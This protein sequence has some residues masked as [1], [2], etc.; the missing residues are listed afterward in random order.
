MSHIEKQVRVAQNRLWLNR[1]MDQVTICLAVGIL[2]FGV[3]V[4][5]SRLWGLSLPVWR[6]GQIIA[7]LAGLGSAVWLSLRHET[8]AAAASALDEAAGLR[9]RLSTSRF[10]QVAVD[11]AVTGD[12]FAQAV[13]T[14]AD[15]AAR[16]LSVSKIIKLRRPRFLGHLAAAALVAACFFLLPAGWLVRDA[17]AELPPV[18]QAVVDANT[19]IKKRLDDLAKKVEDSTTADLKEDLQALRE[20]ISAPLERP[21]FVRHEALKKIEKLSD[22]VKEKQSDPKF[23]GMNEF[24]RMMRGLTI[25]EKEDVPTKELQKALAQGDFKTAQEE[26]KKLQEQLATLKM[27]EDQEKINQLSEQLEKIAEELQKAAANKQ[28]EQKLQ[29]AGIKPDDLKRMLENLSKEDLQQVQ[30]QLEQQGM[31]QQQIDQIVKQMQQN[32]MAGSAAKQMANNMKQAA[33]CNNP[34]Q[35]G[36]AMSGLSQAADQLS[37]LE[38][39]QAEMAQLDSTMQSLN[40]AQN[41]MGGDCP[42]CKGTGQCKGGPCSSCKGSGM[43]QGQNRNGM[44][45]KPGQGQGGVAPEEQT[46]VDFKVERQQLDTRKGAI[47]GQFLVDGEQV[48]G[49]VTSQLVEVISAAER[50]ATDNVERDRIPR[51]YQSAVRSYFSSVKSALEGMKKKPDGAKEGEGK[52]DEG[53]EAKEATTPSSP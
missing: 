36:Q 8:S 25:P 47:I 23:D 9:E 24:R 48:E 22:A 19:Q 5:V 16:D 11:P 13:V 6:I 45:P 35:M 33:Q 7:A 46:S 15:R 18:S 41:E 53:A 37:D 17:Q 30:K 44:G 40:Q 39:M 10:L 51:H 14:D 29:Q 38:A 3:V 32:Q 21:D 52:G 50:D 49:E 43:C 27:E 28:L 2:A 31:S 34:G 1:W 42:Q 20:P 12:P 26:V 4:G